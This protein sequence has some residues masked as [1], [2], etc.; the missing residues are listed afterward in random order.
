MQTRKKIIK[1]QKYSTGT[2]KTVTNA[3]RC[4]LLAI[5]HFYK[6]TIKISFKVL[7]NPLDIQIFPPSNLVGTKIH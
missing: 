1:N 6:F 7:G 2:L 3:Q 5:Q 4:T